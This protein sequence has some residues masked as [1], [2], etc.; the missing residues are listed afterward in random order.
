MRAGPAGRTTGRSGGP[1]SDYLPPPCGKRLK[2]S[3]GTEAPLAWADGPARRRQRESEMARTPW[4]AVGG[5]HGI[6]ARHSPAMK[7]LDAPGLVERVESIAAEVDGGQVGGAE[8]QVGVVGAALTG[9]IRRPTVEL[10]VSLV[11]WTKR[12]ANAKNQPPLRR[13]TPAGQRRRYVDQPEA[14]AILD[15]R[16][17]LTG[18]G[19]QEPQ[20]LI[21]RSHLCSYAGNQ[22]DLEDVPPQRRIGVSGSGDQRIQS[23]RAVGTPLVP[24]Q[25]HSVDGKS[26]RLAVGLIHHAIARA[27]ALP[28]DLEVGQLIA[29]PA[30]V[31]G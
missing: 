13:V 8:L 25:F 5:K 17:R 10:V 23:Q 1:R 2:R 21:H 19:Q 4:R 9:R 15:A 12:V 6:G 27:E 30:R 22:V 3:P 26:S 18:V 20:R 28:I 24:L 31:E 14:D 11:P 29:P 16:L 7:L